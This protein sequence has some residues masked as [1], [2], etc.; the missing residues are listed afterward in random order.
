M[1]F[2]KVANRKRRPRHP[3]LVVS[4]QLA[5]RVVASAKRFTLAV[6]LPGGIA[7][8][9]RRFASSHRP[10]D[11]SFP[12][13]SPVLHCECLTCRARHV[14]PKMNPLRRLLGSMSCHFNEDIPLNF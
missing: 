12:R 2:Q 14:Q 4:P 6:P 8:N 10:P 13:S 5:E 1:P 3:P 11:S 7:P 9:P